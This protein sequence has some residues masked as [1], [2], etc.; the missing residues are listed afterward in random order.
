MLAAS[1]SGVA[2]LASVSG[3]AA[4]LA[5]KNVPHIVNSRDKQLDRIEGAEGALDDA[6]GAD[7]D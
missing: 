3:L 7:D 5:N 1:S 6:E 2:V 4:K